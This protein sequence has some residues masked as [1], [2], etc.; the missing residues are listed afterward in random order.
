MVCTILHA[1]RAWSVGRGS[2]CKAL[3]P[4]T[5]YRTPRQRVS[6]KL[7]CRPATGQISEEPWKDADGSPRHAACGSTKHVPRDCQTPRNAGAIVND[8]VSNPRTRCATASMDGRA[9]GCRKLRVLDNYTLGMLPK[10]R[11][12]FFQTM[13]CFLWKV[14]R[15][16]LFRGAGVCMTPWSG[17]AL[18]G[19]CCEVW[20]AAIL[21]DYG[22]KHG[23]KLS[24]GLLEN[25]WS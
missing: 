6:S 13:I 19:G 11:I 24:M 21:V 15:T 4:C 5:L 12:R 20:K 23:E 14:S 16:L 18:S 22:E 25:S 8:F 2:E 1:L 17:M 10:L 3:Y 7:Y 9:A